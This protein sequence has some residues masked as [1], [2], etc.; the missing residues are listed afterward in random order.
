MGGKKNYVKRIM[1]KKIMRKELC[2]KELCEKELCKRKAQ[3]TWEPDGTKES[4][5]E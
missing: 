3:G 5:V 1:W 4:S 2:G